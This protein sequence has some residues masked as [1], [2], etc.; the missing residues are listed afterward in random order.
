MEKDFFITAVPLIEFDG[1]S[2]VPTVLYYKNESEPL[3]GES[4]LNEVKNRININQDFKVDIGNIDPSS[5]KNNRKFLTASGQKISAIKLTSDFLRQVLKDVQL[6]FDINGISK[7]KNIMISEPLSLQS[8]MASQEWLSRYRNNIKKI[9]SGSLYGFESISF[10]PEPFAVFQYYRYGLKHPSLSQYAK[11]NA[12][13]IDFGG[14]TFDV[15]IIETTKSGDI[16]IK[17][18]NSR[19]LAASSIAVGGYYINRK[20]AE[21]LI[22][23]YHEKNIPNKKIRNANKLYSE[24]RE[25]EKDFSDFKDVQTFIQNFHN[26]IYDLES[27]KIALCNSIAKWDI[28]KIP[29]IIVPISVPSNP[30]KPSGKKIDGKLSA[31][32][33][34]Q[35]YL[36]QVWKPHLQRNIKIA[37]KR[38]K[39]ELKSGQVSVILLSGGS[40]N[41]G[42]LRQLIISDFY[43]DFHDIEIFPL[44]NYQEVVAQGLAIECARRFY[45]DDKQGD[46]SSVTYNRICLVMNPNEEGYQVRPFRTKTDN[47]P[48]VQS[49]PGVLLPSASL[50]NRFVESPMRWKVKLS[51][52]PSRQLQY[53]FLRSSLNP[54][55]LENILNIQNHTVYTTPKTKFDAYMQIE[56]TLREN[57]TAYPR[58]IFKSGPNDQIIDAKEG[59]PFPIDLTTIQNTGASAYIGFD[60]G[61]SNSSISFVNETSIQTYSKRK[62]DTGWED[63]AT[64][65][66][67]LPYPIAVELAKYLSQPDS[68]QAT[69]H[70]L[71]LLEAA[72]SL[73]SYITYSEYCA[74]K[75]IKQTK[76]FKGFTQRSLGPLIGFFKDCIKEIPKGSI[77]AENFKDLMKDEYITAID[78][79]A[80]KLAQFKHGKI[81][82]S[83]INHTYVIQILTNTCNKAFK[84]NYFG[85]FEQV[86]KQKFTKKYVGRFRKAHG[87]TPFINTL[88]YEGEDTYSED[89]PILLNYD[90]GKLL[91][92]QPLI[93]WDK[94]PKHE[95]I[96]EGHLYFYD[97]DDG[98]GK[99]SFKAAGFNCTITLSEDSQYAPIV[100]RLNE[101]SS[102]D[103]STDICEGGEFKKI[104][105]T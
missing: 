47:L 44:P 27:A 84:D 5:T 31:K 13:V 58:F 93:F 32:D 42:W 24:W 103:C 10:L 87:R 46:F 95:S 102:L 63:L 41:I 54:E 9:L 6:W 77:F 8:D 14:G 29:D 17:G 56:L 4:A 80:K 33:F 64:L 38:S 36:N 39:E 57:G 48:N 19:P 45:T 53:R 78:D 89:E 52:R 26:L 23:K 30:F 76:K 81:D 68:A 74:I 16:R 15:C 86:Q 73:I 25:G 34:F 70:A 61:T 51:K 90:Q 83:E 69:K 100:S 79:C 71:D 59:D 85:F 49:T 88:S 82:S 20:L 50:L 11:H 35:V 72:F 91:F 28:E 12:M 66:E 67:Q 7:P 96:A 2:N 40:A 21:F 101:L 62:V 1:S 3:Y 75:G 37:L 105:I 22:V 97:K 65:V 55:D 99:Y 92:L 60:F 104:I 98:K 94:C 43:D 18:R